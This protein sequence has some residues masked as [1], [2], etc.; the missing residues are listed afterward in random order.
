MPR[1]PSGW[2]RRCPPRVD[3]V[4][5]AELVSR[6]LG[7]PGDSEE[8]SS[9]TRELF[10][11]PPIQEEGASV[12]GELEGHASTTH[13]GA[14][15]VTAGGDSRSALLGHTGVV[16]APVV[17]SPI[18]D[19]VGKQTPTPHQRWGLCHL[20]VATCS[21]PMPLHQRWGWFQIRTLPRVRRR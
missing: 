6:A 15:T 17:D 1:G 5:E 3:R 11:P 10:P 16:T 8:P 21:P 20:P 7:P 12:Q 14:G 2:P 9:Q 18:R 13:A 19:L 4:E